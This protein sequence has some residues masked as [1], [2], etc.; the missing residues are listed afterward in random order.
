MSS[1]PDRIQSPR[2]DGF[3]RAIRSIMLTL[4]RRQ[5]LAVMIVYV[6]DVERICASL[7]HI[8]ADKVMDNF[9]SDLYTIARKNDV[10]ERI[11]DRKFAVLLSGLRNHGH[12]NLAARKIERLARKIAS[13]HSEKSTLNTTIG[14]V[15]CP[16]QGEDAYELMRLAEIA[17]L[18][19][20]CRNK[21]VCFYETQSADQLVMDWGLEDRLAN[22]LESDE[23]ELHYQPKKSLH[24]SEIVGAEALMRWHEP[25]IGS[26]SPD[27]FIE[28]A[29]ATGQITDLTHFAIQRA[30]RQLSEWQEWLPGLRIAL[31]ISPSIIQNTEI[32]DV[33]QNATSIWGIRP[34]A[35]T[36]EVT[37][38][39]L[40][41]DPETSHDVLTR[42]RAFG[43]R[44][45]ID[46][47]G[48]GYSSLAYL[49]D[50]PADEL[51]IDR[52]FVMDMLTDS[53]NYKIVEH[54]I[55]IA[56]SFA[57]SVVAEGVENAETLEQLRI[58]GCDD[59]QGYFI[60]KPVPADEF[61]AFCRD[62]D[63]S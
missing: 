22:A 35:L 11:G 18:D 54:T 21:S 7:G 20:R 6:H 32:V 14:V 19:G 12:V 41:A 10:I 62:S 8:Q 51:K 24:T 48:T 46:D 60:C 26:I 3:S 40:M 43:A 50:I 55:Q 23:L 33:L 31:N 13:S 52:S 17:A 29:E 34:D 2:G 15:M 5:D 58:L 47:F 9:Y 36:M 45:S 28:L 27:V 61:E 53:G 30:C 1:Q 4:R 37:E 42:I 25:E 63:G 44:V 49:K 56:K 16:E 57:L 38:N 39:A 59:A